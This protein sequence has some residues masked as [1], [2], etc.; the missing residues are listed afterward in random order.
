MATLSQLVQLATGLHQLGRLDEAQRLYRT[1]LAVCPD[2]AEILNNLALIVGGEEA[3]TLLR[4]AI[5]LKPDYIEAHINLGLVLQGLGRNREA[6]SCLERAL[7]LDPGR[8]DIRDALFGVLSLSGRLLS[9]QGQFDEAE[10]CFQRAATLDPDHAETRLDQGH[11]LYMLRRLDEA[12]AACDAA[13]RIKPDLGEGHGNRGNVLMG[14]GRLEEALASY[15]VALRIKPDCAET[16]YNR[17]LALSALARLDEALVAYETTLRIRPELTEAHSNLI[18][19]LD[20]HEGVGVERLQA[21]RRRWNDLHAAPLAPPSDHRPL[22]PPD[23]GRRLRI[24]YVSADF[25]RH[26]AFCAFAPVIFNHDRRHFEP[27][28][29][30]NSAVEDD[31]TARLRA[32]V[33]EWRSVFRLSDQD[34]AALIRADGIDVLVDLSGHTSGN[35]LLVFARKPAPVQ[36]TAWGYATGTGLVTMDALFADPIAAPPAQRPLLVEPVI[37]LPCVL[38]Y[39]PPP[40]LPEV[41]PREQGEGLVFG[42][43]NRFV[44]IGDAVLRL[45][46]ELLRRRPDA[47]LVLKNAALDHPATRERAMARLAGAGV[48]TDRIRLLGGSGHGDHLAAYH[49]IDVALDPFPHGGGITTAEALWMGVPVLTLR[50]TTMPGR[51]SASMLTA[52]G[53][54][55]WIADDGEDY[56]ARACALVP[57]SPLL[58]DLRM[59]L[60]ARMSVSPVGDVAAYTSAVEAAYRTLWH[61]WC[62]SSALGRRSG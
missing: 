30:A 21:E 59:G 25:R 22:N 62:H 58:A 41:R 3:G 43:F 44:K 36:V 4:R 17:G 51:T 42:C 56:L 13:L 34:L 24:G 29:Y 7:A 40:Y 19:T 49:H 14:L 61:R 15:D 47:L 60:R 5:A 31:H 55:E 2:I 53:L 18:Y 16:H 50:G 38:C 1:I 48:D 52:A 28:C 11:A 20:H 23:P 37:D 39:Q 33:P 27:V 10:A 54:A 45:W 12:V 9:S 26:S 32:V 57:C 6:T 46:R 8:A 35:R